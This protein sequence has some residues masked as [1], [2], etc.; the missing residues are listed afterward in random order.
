[1][2][3]KLLVSPQESGD[4]E[5][6]ADVTAWRYDTN[7]VDAAEI[8][9]SIGEDLLVEPKSPEYKRNMI[10]LTVGKIALAAAGV[11]GVYFLYKI[12]KEKFKVWMSQD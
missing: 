8:N 2:T 3:F 7:Y 4:Y 12:G 1:M 6:I 5:I 9:L 10:F 11:A